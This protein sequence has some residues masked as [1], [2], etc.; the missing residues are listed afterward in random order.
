MPRTYTPTL[1]LVCTD[2]G[3]YDEYDRAAAQVARWRVAASNLARRG[4]R[5][6]RGWR[7]ARKERFMV[8]HANRIAAK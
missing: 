5:Y 2:G 8:R 6:G 7:L 1:A 4:L 3:V